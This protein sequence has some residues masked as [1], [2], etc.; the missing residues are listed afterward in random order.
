MN[1]TFHQEPFEIPKEWKI[2]LWR[3]NSD[4]ASP[5]S[6]RY[7]ADRWDENAKAVSADAPGFFGVQE[8]QLSLHGNTYITFGLF[9]PNPDFLMIEADRRDISFVDDDEISVSRGNIIGVF[10]KAQFQSMFQPYSYMYTD[11]TFSG[12]IKASSELL[13]IEWLASPS[14]PDGF[15]HSLRVDKGINLLGMRAGIKRRERD[16]MRFFAYWHDVV[17]AKGHDP[18]HGERA[19]EVIEQ[20]RGRNEFK[21]VDVDRLSFACKHHSTMLRSGDPLIDICLDADRLDLF[22][23]GITPDPSLMATEVGAYYAEHYDE[24]LTDIQ[25]IRI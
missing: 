3:F 16:R 20:G 6:A 13:N 4:G 8:E 14:A 9:T 23:R 7:G 2:T 21:A 25:K 17:R 24:Y 11:N 15:S 1:L 12:Y 10:D 5:F 22:Y 18:E 19:S